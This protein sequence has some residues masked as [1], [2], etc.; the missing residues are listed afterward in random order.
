[1]HLCRVEAADISVVNQSTSAGP[2]DTGLPQV[3]CHVLGSDNLSRGYVPTAYNVH[4][5]LAVRAVGD[6][7]R[8]KHWTETKNYP[9]NELISVQ[10]QSL[11][12]SDLQTKSVAETKL[13]TQLETK[14][15]VNLNKTVSVLNKTPTQGTE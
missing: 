4:S 7:P 13:R 6:V 3:Y 15:K 1:M 9:Q 5:V 10:S 8:S 11:A 14:S 12:E 2:C